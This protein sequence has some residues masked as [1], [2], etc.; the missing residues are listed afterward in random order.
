MPTVLKT[1]DSETFVPTE[2]AGSYLPL[3]HELATRIELVASALDGRLGLSI[4]YARE[5]VYLQF[6]HICELIAL[7]CLRLHGDL[8][9]AQSSSAQKEW[10]A[11]KIMRLLQRRHPHCFP[12][13]VIRE[14]TETGWTIRAN[15]KPNAL[16]FEE[17]RRLYALC[18]ESLHRG[19]IR[20]IQSS[21]P[22][23]DSDLQALIRWQVKIVDLM[24]VHLV[25]RSSGTGFFLI[26][27]RTDSGYPECS[28]F[29]KNGE[30]GM[31]VATQKI[32]VVAS[33]HESLIL[34]GNLKPVAA[35]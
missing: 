2:A 35:R 21:A 24:N 4:P 8:P 12:Q 16:T 26:S 5:Y 23:D 7:G 15:A 17:F 20:S 32:E 28:V 11:E 9:E 6:R 30:Q 22:L 31:D 18:G 19:T 33:G 27:L 14:K 29:T 25:G 1:I 3:M 34:F 10:H 13:S